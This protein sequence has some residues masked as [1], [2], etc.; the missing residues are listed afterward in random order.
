MALTE[1]PALVFFTVFIFAFLRM[2]DLSEVATSQLLEI[3]V[4]A[5]LCLGAAIL[6][7]QTY[8]VALPSTALMVFWL[9]KKWLPLLVCLSVA[10]LT[11]GWLF[12]LWRGLLPPAYQMG[13]SGVSLSHGMLSL[14]YI[15]GATLFLNPLWMKPLNRTVFIGCSVAGI[16]LAILS[17]QYANA[18]AKSLLLRIFPEPVA[19]LVGFL[20]GCTL[21][22][23]GAMW[24][25]NALHGAWTHRRDAHSAFSYLTLFALV[26]APMKV[27]HQ[28][29]S[30]YV[31]GTLGV[32]FLVIA[33]RELG[34][35][36]AI[37]LGAGSLI[38]AAML[39]TYFR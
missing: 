11:S 28:F 24:L 16:S 1:L 21:S 35:W 34:F 3:A 15:A 12:V 25:C 20:I 19:L 32:L 29:S 22:V 18:P 9:P 31:V 38:G 7:R 14:S 5:G 17:R 33:P 8:L 2:I 4:I 27:I 13:D 36:W 37:R 30:R 6:G 39:W 26:S 23:L 10:L